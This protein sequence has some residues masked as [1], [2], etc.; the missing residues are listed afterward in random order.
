MSD[1]RK[2]DAEDTDLPQEQRTS[3]EET[4]EVGETTETGEA[5]ETTEVGEAS[6]EAGAAETVEP[7]EPVETQDG[8]AEPTDRRA[9]DDEKATAEPVE[10]T[11]AEPV[12]NTTAEP[13]E[14]ATDAVPSDTTPSGTKDNG[15][16]RRGLRTA[17][18]IA[19]G[20]LL[21]AAVAA[22][23]V[24]PRFIPDSGPRDVG[25]PQVRSGA[26]TSSYVCPPTV[27]RVGDDATS[28]QAYAAGAQ[29]AGSS[30]SV[31]AQG[32]QAQRVPGVSVLAQDRTVT[33]LSDDLPADEAEDGD[34]ARATDGYSGVKG[35]AD[36]AVNTAAAAWVKVQPLGGAP[37]PAAATRTVQQ[38]SGDLTGFA[39]PSCSLANNTVWL[40]GATT[41]VGHTAVLSVTNPSDTP[42]GLS[43]SVYTDQGE[44]TTGGIQPFTLKAG[45]TRS[46]NLG[47]TAVDADVSAVKV[48]S[49]GAAVS[50]S[51]NQTILRGTTPGGIDTITASTPDTTQVMTGVRVPGAKQAKALGTSDSAGDET[52]QVQIA[53]ATGAGA[54]VSVLARDED[55][56]TTEL[57]KAAEVPP[58]GVLGV[59]LSSL[60]EGTWTIEVQGT[61]PVVATSR[62]LKGTDDDAARDVDYVAATPA[63]STD[64]FV[65]VPTKG[66]PSLRLTA[67]GEDATVDVVP[68]DEDGNPGETEKITVKAGRI[69][70]TSMDDLGDPAG[71]RLSGTSGTAYA[72]VTTTQGKAGIGSTAV[73]QPPQAPGSTTVDVLP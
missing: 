3:P 71:L 49:S 29:K 19:S 37:S 35:V 8:D 15:R 52:P 54:Q 61:D 21:V 22:A 56:K 27:Q 72:S 62:T 41:T 70:T 46:L 28:D 69:A 42:A 25:I 40:T 59:D 4:T 18:G 14:K 67:T 63:L 51:I 23:A 10:N 44:T 32:D 6:A 34:A 16:R 38:G 2:P 26:G 36:Q 53:D 12:E 47:G 9:D 31:L 43:V 39:A 64:Q 58:D 68:V 33:K 1:E 13:D 17:V 50:A 30:L 5:G 45:E 57:V 24:A 48:E 20:A 7:V 55:G 60:A 73:Q 66:S 11:A 65:A